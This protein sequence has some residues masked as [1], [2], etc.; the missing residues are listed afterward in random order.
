MKRKSRSKSAA[1]T[2]S[3][4]NDN[5]GGRRSFYMVG[6]NFGFSGIDSSVKDNM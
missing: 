5:G 1:P 2:N 6:D 4:S 3:S